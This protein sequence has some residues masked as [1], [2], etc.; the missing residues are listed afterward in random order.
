MNTSN[1]P[2][3]VPARELRSLREEEDELY[4]VLSAFESETTGVLV[5]TAPRAERMILHILVV[6]LTSLVALSALVK[7]DRVVTGQGEMVSVGGPLYVSPLNSGVIK[8]VHVKPGDIVKKGSDK[9]LIERLTSE[10]NDRPYQPSGSNPYNDLQ[11]SI[12]H[13]RHAEYAANIANY[14]AQIRNAQAI[15]SQYQSDARQ[16]R[17]RRDL[18]LER[19]NMMD[20]LAGKGYV[21]PL[22]LNSVR[23]SREEA[24]RQYSAAQSQ[25]VSQQQIE[26]AARAQRAAYVEKWHADVGSQ[27][28][29]ARNDLDAQSQNLEKAEKLLELGT[30]TSPA[31]AIVLKIAKIS[32][33]AVATVTAPGD[34]N[35]PQLF[36]LAPLDAP[37]EAEIQVP[38]ADIGFIRVG[39]PVMVKLDAYSFIRHGTAKGEIKSISEGSF[40]TNDNNQPVPPYFK[41]RVKM[42]EVKLHDVPQDFRLIPGMT[43]AGD[44]MVGRRTILS[45]FVEGTLRTGSE[46]MR[47]AQ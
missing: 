25:I 43:L 33:G 26:S 20:P 12:W 4:D 39:D 17:K 5:R 2:V 3:K 31:D 40:T 7:V 15:I 1:L 24:E 37:L 22:Q 28:V 14:D 10:Q 11:L 6:M 38:A 8:A 16:Y 29:A 44:V 19:E 47:E 32:A 18:A 27:L 21:S 9:A 42:T 45:Y 36:T 41:V 13:Q 35:Y 46:A 23:D 34:A 30:L